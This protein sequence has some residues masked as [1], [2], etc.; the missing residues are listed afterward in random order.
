MNHKLIYLSVFVI[1][2]QLS[3]AQDKAKYKVWNPANDTLNV[4][5]GQGWPKK[6]KDY[7]DRL[8]AKAEGIVRTE[9]WKLSKNNAGVN[10]RFRTN[11][12]EIIVKYV[13]KGNLQL[14][15]MP[16]T[17]VSGVDLYAKD[18]DGRWLWSAG[19]FSFG[20]T[21]TYRFNNLE[22]A[23][24][25]DR[26]YTL[27]L[28]LYNAVK[29]M[30][31]YV[32]SEKSFAP[33]PLHQE[34]P[35]VV[36]GTSIA[37]GACATRPGLAWTSIL[38][39]KLDQPV[40]NLGFSGNGRLEKEVVDLLTEIDA[41][42]YVLDRLP[43][44]ISISKEDLAARIEATVLQLQAKRPGVPILLTEHDGYTD[45]LI[46]PKRKTDYDNPNITLNDAF[47]QLKAKG[48]KNIY[49]LSKNEIGQ[50]IE[51]TVDGVHPND[52]G[53]MNYANAYE[54]T[55][56]KL[57]NQPEGNISTTKPTTQYRELPGYDWEKRHNEVLNHNKTNPPQLVFIGNS[58]THFWSGEPLAHVARGTE[59]WNKYF[60]DKSP[61]NMGFGWDRIENVLWRVY[62]GELDGFAAKQIILMIGTNNLQFNTDAQIAEGLKV[63]ITAIKARQP[64]AKILV[65]G[66][67]PRREMEVRVAKLN[68][69]YA[70][71]ALNLKVQYADAGS[72]L[73][74]IRKK[75]NEALFTDGLH[76]NAQGYEKLGAFIN[77]Q[78]TNN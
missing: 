16:A 2:S 71:I 15:H 9:V 34:K 8:P 59:S 57:L 24:N 32:P 75:V 58:I 54:R 43:N 41:K 51:S 17:G 47:K 70:K 35:I 52:I 62:H 78:I 65:L 50:D 11:S 18:R 6:V 74:N 10:L 72:L 19:A 53:M 31:I 39:R 49:L 68:L 60:K 44:L 55:I 7:Y 14:S 69:L 29:W 1:I 38:Q 28:P 67:L 56:K 5:E 26:E 45:E 33:M 73:L 77:K 40:I 42:L 46:S 4:L 3:I 25:P 48:I 36:Y 61:L 63:L 76:P 27:Y 12:N 37:Q 20:D 13:V 22:Q 23:N 66:L 64:K 21:I 30:E